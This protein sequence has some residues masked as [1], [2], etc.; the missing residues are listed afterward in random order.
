MAKGGRRMRSGRKRT[1][2]AIK[3]VTGAFRSD[4]H[5]TE[6]RGVPLAWPDP[7]PH[8]NARERDLW[9]RLGAECGPWVAPSD[10]LA[11]NGTV[12]LVDRLLTVQATEPKDVSLEMKLWTALRGYIAILGLSPADRARM[13]AASEPAA[14]NPLDRFIKRGR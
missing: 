5:G 12:S 2:T 14:E 10:W 4:R 7:P 1:P 3:V 8:L 6:P 9:Q 13:P 11:I